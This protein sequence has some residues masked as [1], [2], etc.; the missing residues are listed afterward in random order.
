MKIY[1]KIVIDIETGDVVE[2]ECF[3]YDGEFVLCKGGGAA[4]KVEYPTYVRQ[5]QFQMMSL[6]G[7]DAFGP[8]VSVSYSMF[9]AIN[10]SYGNSPYTGVTASIPDTRISNWETGIDDYNTI[11]DTIS[12]TTDWAAFFTQAVTTIDTNYTDPSV[13]AAADI[14]TAWIDPSNNAWTDIDGDWDESQPG[15]MADIEADVAAYED[16]ADDRV[17]TDVLPRFQRG[18]QDINAVMTSGFTIGQ[19][20]I[21]GMTD[22]DISKYHGTLRVAANTQRNQIEA[23]SVL[24]KNKQ[25]AT[26]YRRDDELLA[27]GKKAESLALAEAHKQ[28]D[29]INA[30]SVNQENAMYIQSIEQMTR[31]FLAKLSGEEAYSRINLAGQMAALEAQRVE[32]ETQLEID[33]A[34]AMWDLSIFQ[35][36]GNLLASAAGGTAIPLTTRPTRTQAMVG[37][38]MAGAGTGAVV[39]GGNPYVIAGG[40]LLGAYMGYTQGS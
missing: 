27:E 24:E 1:T 2:Q 31:F 40:A 4:G 26:A 16:I 39:G 7:S 33:A 14:D 11:L 10:A 30:F 35:F 21:E 12:E 23:E 18:M 5:L 29:R 38:A 25:K 34:D 36:G 13:D 19:A 9:D 3:D 15:S 22:R 32:T 20:I 28:D 6:G 37:G 8:N 17:T